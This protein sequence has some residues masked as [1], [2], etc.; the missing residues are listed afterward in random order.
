MADGEVF[1]LRPLPP[2]IFCR[3]CRQTHGARCGTNQAASP[4]A[5]RYDVQ[6]CDAR[7]RTN[8]AYGAAADALPDLLNLNDLELVEAAGVEPASEKARRVK[9][10][11]VSD[12]IVSAAA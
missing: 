7:R 4:N 2:G 5:S 10:T 8:H 12:S 6:G 1:R 3:T 11:C 9:P